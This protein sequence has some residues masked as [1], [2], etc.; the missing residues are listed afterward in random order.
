MVRHAPGVGLERRRIEIPVG[1][2]VHPE[3]DRRVRGFEGRDVLVET[4][5]RILGL[6]P[7]HT[8]VA[9][10]EAEVR[11]SRVK[12][13]LHKLGVTALVGD[14]VADENEAVAVL[15]AEAARRGGHDGA[16]GF[17]GRG[18]FLLGVDGGGGH[19]KRAA[20][21]GCCSQ[22]RIATEG[23]EVHRGFILCVTRCPL[24]FN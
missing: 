21:G 12:E 15:Q 7:A 11:I 2:V 10:V 14:R 5:E 13:V 17:S 1:S 6:V 9:E 16:D 20:P 24:W 4:V 3:Q 19:D 8:R 22:M 23:T 18:R